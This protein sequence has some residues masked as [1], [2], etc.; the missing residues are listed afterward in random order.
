MFQLIYPYD[1]APFLPLP[2]A[3]HPG[4]MNHAGGEMVPVVEP[5]GLVIGQTARSL[6]HGGTGASEELGLREFNPI[7]LR[8]YVWESQRERELVNVFAAVGNFRID[9]CNE[10]VPEGRYWSFAEIESALGKDVF[11]PNFE[12]EFKALGSSLLALL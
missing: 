5:S 10:E 3:E 7:Y 1:P 9:P 11:T 12:H 6:A 8:S 4:G 2:T